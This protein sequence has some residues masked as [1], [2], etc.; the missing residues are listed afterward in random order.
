MVS[1]EQQAIEFRA[2]CEIWIFSISRNFILIFDWAKCTVI[3]KTGFI[4]ALYCSIWFLFFKEGDT[5]EGEL[6]EYDDESNAPQAVSGVVPEI[7]AAAAL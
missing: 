6:G 3:L 2:R 1:A 5:D 4:L 7:A